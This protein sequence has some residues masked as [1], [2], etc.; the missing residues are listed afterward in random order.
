MLQIATTSCC[1]LHCSTVEKDALSLFLR[2][3]ASKE[4]H[5]FDE[6]DGLFLTNACMLK[7]NVVDDWDI[8]NR[9]DGN[10]S[11]HDSPEQELVALYIVHPLGEVLLRLRL[12]AEERTAHV[13]HLLGKEKGKLGEVDKGGSA[14]AKDSVAHFAV[15]IVAA[16][17]KVAVTEPKEDNREGCKV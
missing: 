4:E 6:H 14:R 11:S 8:K 7:D 13:Y 12:H 15:C 1:K 10:K 2:F 9:E 3:D 5:C 16:S 17:A